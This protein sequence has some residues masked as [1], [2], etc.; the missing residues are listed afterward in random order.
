MEA[1]LATPT[2]FSIG[3][4]LVMGSAEQLELMAVEQSPFRYTDFLGCAIVCR[5]STFPFV[6]PGEP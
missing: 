6:S 5:H 3:S 4:A 2:S 1:V